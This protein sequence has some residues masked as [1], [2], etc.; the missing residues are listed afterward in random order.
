MI[1][2]LKKHCFFYDLLSS[3]SIDLSSFAIDLA[4]PSN[5]IL[6]RDPIYAAIVFKLYIFFFSADIRI[7]ASDKHLKIIVSQF[8]HRHINWIEL[9]KDRFVNSK[10]KEKKMSEKMDTD[11]ELPFKPFK[12]DTRTLLPEQNTHKH[13]EF[14]PTFLCGIKM[15]KY[16]EWLRDVT[17]KELFDVDEFF[18]TSTDN[19]VV[20]DTNALKPSLGK[21]KFRPE[22]HS[23]NKIFRWNVM[24]VELNDLWLDI[25]CRAGYRKS[26]VQITIVTCEINYYRMFVFIWSNSFNVIYPLTYFVFF[27]DFFLLRKYEFFNSNTVYIIVYSTYYIIIIL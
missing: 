12:L 24:N 2:V 7:T 3:F 17:Y 15:N 4:T 10:Q 18:W 9:W 23:Q 8:N 26:K 13:M 19:D 16:N 14:L 20:E 6:L 25:L 1:E 22:Y 11:V 21:S 27:G 5:Q